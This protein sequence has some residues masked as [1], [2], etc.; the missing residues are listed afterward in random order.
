MTGTS[1]PAAPVHAKRVSEAIA[2]RRSVRA[3]KDRPVP[4]E[5]IAAILAQAARAPSGGN[6]QPWHVIVLGGAQLE[7]FRTGMRAAAARGLGS[8]PNQYEVYPASLPAPYEDRRRKVGEDMYRQI[9]IAREDREG[10]RSWFQN[11]FQF[12]GAPVGILIHTPAL[13]GPPQWADLGIWLQT[14]MLL[15]REYGLDSCAQEA[16]SVFHTSVRAL[17]P[18]P[19]DHILMAG[20]AIG[21]ADHDHAV[22]G[23]VSDRAALSDYVTWMFD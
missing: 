18:I 11:N 7:I 3:F 16:W 6:L 19:E 9:G 15:L 14:V 22:N 2:T 17:V 12:F 23:L 4:R 21:Y 8:E 10:R 20:M 1:R 13:M 5:T